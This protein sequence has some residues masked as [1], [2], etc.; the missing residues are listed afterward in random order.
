M[1]NLPLFKCEVK[2]TVLHQYYPIQSNIIL[3]L[4]IRIQILIFQA[5]FQRV[6]SSKSATKARTLSFIAA[7]GCML[8]SIPPVLIGAIARATGEKHI[9][10]VKTA[11]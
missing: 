3:N 2:N 9:H 8:M 6:L 7:F 5:Y 4:F 1:T 11:L 10:I